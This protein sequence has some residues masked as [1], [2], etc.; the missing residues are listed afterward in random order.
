MDDDDDVADEDVS[1]SP[2]TRHESTSMSPCTVRAVCKV[3][4]LMK[5]A[6]FERLKEVLASEEGS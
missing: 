6:A 5:P 2:G 3:E 4:L 1:T